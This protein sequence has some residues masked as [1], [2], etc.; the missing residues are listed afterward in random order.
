MINNRYIRIVFLT[1]IIL[2]GSLNIL[3][4]QHKLYGTSLLS[5]QI[6]NAY[7][8]S[9][10][11]KSINLIEFN[12][13]VRTSKYQYE[14]ESI[15]GKNK[16]KLEHKKKTIYNFLG[17]NPPAVTFVNFVGKKVSS[18]G[19]GRKTYINFWGLSCKPCIEEL[20]LI[21]S[22]AK[23]FPKV[24]FLAIAYDDDK[25]VKQ[26]LL[27]RHST[28]QYIQSGKPL[29][30]IFEVDYYPMHVIIDEKN[31]ISTIIPGTLDKSKLTQLLNTL[32]K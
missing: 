28:L 16:F 29:T 3:A 21:D 15:D 6:K 25:D 5:D 7:F 19:N 4:Q 10:L 22:I 2:F 1:Q 9:L 20:S 27:K 30:K 18:V 32:S 24:N 12:D 23:K 8:Y 14:I 26:F 13:S 31:I 17:K 11:G